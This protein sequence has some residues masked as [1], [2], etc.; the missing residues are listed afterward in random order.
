MSANLWMRRI[1][2]EPKASGQQTGLAEVWTANL[3]QA[4]VSRSSRTKTG[5][6]GLFKYG[7]LVATPK[8]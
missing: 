6:F 3:P 7:N 4:Q 5:L 2:P 1:M 8:G